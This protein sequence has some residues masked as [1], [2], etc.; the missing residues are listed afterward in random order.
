VQ[1]LIDF[2][3][4]KTHMKLDT[5]GYITGKLHTS[6]YGISNISMKQGLEL[7]DILRNMRIDARYQQLETDKNSVEMLFDLNQDQAQN[8]EANVMPKYPNASYEKIEIVP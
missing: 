8:F 2:Y 5:V 7:K 4:S 1:F 3:I 6:T